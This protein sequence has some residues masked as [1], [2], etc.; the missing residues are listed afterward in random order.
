MAITSFP[1]FLFVCAVLILYFIVPRKWQWTALLIAS[2]AFYLSYGV[3]HIL[4]V[5]YTAAS[6]H[7]AARFIQKR[8]DEQK[9]YLKG[10]G[11]ALSREE[12]NAY[13]TKNKSRKKAET[14]SGKEAAE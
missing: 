5:L 3:K 10:E 9:A 1:F 14:A 4:Y 13:K 6:V 7:F 8:T 11:K 12:K 2:C